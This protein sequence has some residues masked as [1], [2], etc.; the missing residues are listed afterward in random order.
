M[1]V[2]FLLL[3]SEA[4]SQQYSIYCITATEIVGI[5]NWSGGDVCEVTCEQENKVIV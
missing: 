2:F 3:V 1:W 4:F 5:W